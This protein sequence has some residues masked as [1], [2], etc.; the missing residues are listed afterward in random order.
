MKWDIVEVTPAGSRVLA[1][2]FSDGLAGTIRLDPAFCTGVF[3]TLLDDQ[4]LETAMV[5][6]GAVTWPN[7]LDLAPDT[8]YREIS[9]SPTRHY[10]VGSRNS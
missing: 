5:V 1:V 8:M 6:H 7:G 9:S 2:R 10:E 4:V 3:Q